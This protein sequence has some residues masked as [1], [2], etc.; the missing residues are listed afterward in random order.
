MRKKTV[1]IVAFSCLVLAVSSVYAFRVSPVRLDLTIPRGQT[2]ELVLNL[3]GSKGT[4]REYLLVFPTDISME[5]NGTLNFNRLENFEHSAVPWIKLEQTKIALLEKQKKE[6]KFKISVPR[7]AKPGEYYAVIMVE[8][9]EFTDV[10]A[11]DKPFLIHMKSRIAVVIVIDVPGRIYEKKGESVFVKAEEVNGKIKVTSTFHNAGNIH[12]DVSG[13]AVI[14]SK[15]RRISFG[16]V[17]LM[18]VGSQKEEAFIF[19]GNL[20]DF[21]GVLERPLPQGEYIVDVAFDYGYKFKK[22]RFGS[23]FFI[24]RKT[25]IDE[26]KMEFLLAE[27][28]VIELELPVR[29]FRTQI[30]RVVNTDYRPISVSVV[31]EDDWVDVSLSDF[32]LKSGQSRNL[33]AILSV[34][35]D[36]KEKRI[37]K[38]VFKPDRGKPAEIT[39]SVYKPGK[40]PKQKSKKEV[41]K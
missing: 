1:F 11:K 10:R 16:Q 17:K 41:R 32:T 2:A 12:L 34:P 19:P 39:L 37:G 23:N 26:S 35:D 31:S 40:A 28:S 14:R 25:E 8:P 6:L 5:R 13:V 24:T 38:I 18:A 3:T 36:E 9:T 15:D 33:R 29:A 30:I 4:G 21:V 20:R 7:R 22:A 27:P